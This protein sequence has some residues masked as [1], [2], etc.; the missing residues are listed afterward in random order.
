MLSEL[1]GMA[2]STR[3]RDY[4]LWSDGS[5]ADVMEAGWWFYDLT[6]ANLNDAVTCSSWKTVAMKIRPQ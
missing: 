1:N 3:D 6:K 4:D 5:C 2:F